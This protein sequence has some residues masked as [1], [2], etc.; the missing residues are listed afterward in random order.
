MS[1]PLKTVLSVIALTMSAVTA[2]AQMPATI[3]KVT[4]ASANDFVP[5]A[6]DGIPN[7]SHG[8]TLGNTVTF[9]GTA[10]YLTHV[11][12]VFGSHDP[13]ERRVYTPTLYQNNGPKRR[14]EKQL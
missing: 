14:K 9:A 6:D 12:V 4:A 5:F 8:N 13:K 3:Y 7:R 2:S 11:Q 1:I 10:C